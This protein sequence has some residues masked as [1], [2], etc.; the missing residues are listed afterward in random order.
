MILNKKDI[1]IVHE[2]CLSF[3]DP[4]LKA[5]SEI[6]GFVTSLGNLQLPPIAITLTH[7]VL[8][9]HLHDNNIYIYSVTTKLNTYTQ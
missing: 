1:I 2:L 9:V 5:F 8:Y 6:P 4:A 7:Q 3:C